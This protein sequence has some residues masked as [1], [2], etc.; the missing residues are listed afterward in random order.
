MDMQGSRQLAI[1]R[2]QAWEA[3]NDPK[4]RGKVLVGDPRVLASAHASHEE[5]F[6]I[7]ALAGGLGVDA[8]AVSVS[9]RV[10]P[11]QQPSRT[12][13]K[14]PAGYAPNVNGARVFGFV[15]AEQF[16][17]TLERAQREY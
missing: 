7:R 6:L 12:K 13:F 11:K 16:L 3:L 1:T 8:K 17:P 4:Y 5:L 10:T 2:E 9:W 15:P 14:V